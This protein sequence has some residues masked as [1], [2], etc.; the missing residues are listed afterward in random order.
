M[1]PVQLVLEQ[2]WPYPVGATYCAYI[3]RRLPA[4]VSRFRYHTRVVLFFS[5]PVPDNGNVWKQRFG[6]IFAD[7]GLNCLSGYRWY[8]YRDRY[9]RLSPLSRRF[10]PFAPSIRRCSL[11]MPCYYRFPEN[12]PTYVSLGLRKP[13]NVHTEDLRDGETTSIMMR[14]RMI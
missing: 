8:Y 13:Y 14:G 11:E 10:L 1:C 7:F 4:A 2:D 6:S 3:A 9:P 5:F 12:I